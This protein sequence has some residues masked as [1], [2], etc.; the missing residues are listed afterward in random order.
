MSNEYEP[1]LKML[2]SAAGSGSLKN[3]GKI[4]EMFKN[5]QDKADF[6]KVVAQNPDLLK[7]IVAAAMNKDK[8]AARQIL[9]KLMTTP[10]GARIAKTV[11]TLMGE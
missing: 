11:M 7:Q 8:D 2:L 5:P 9:G 6:Q 10:E 4:M 3:I 1:I